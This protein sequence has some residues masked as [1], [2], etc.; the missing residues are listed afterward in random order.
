MVFKVKVAKVIVFKVR[1]AKVLLDVFLMFGLSL[2]LSSPLVINTSCFF[3]FEVKKVKKVTFVVFG[4]Q[5]PRGLFSNAH[6]FCYKQPTTV[7]G[8]AHYLYTIH[9]RFR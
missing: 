5:L 2:K 3:T 1:V 6:I 9:H 7:G 4:I 8:M